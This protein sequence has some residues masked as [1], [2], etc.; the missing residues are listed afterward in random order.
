VYENTE[1]LPRFYLVSRVKWARDFGEAVN[2]LR[3]ADFDP[4]VEAIVEGDG[5]PLAGDGPAGV[6][7][8][9]D[10]SP[11]RVSL[12]VDA[13]SAAFLATSET[14]YPG[15]KAFVDDQPAEL[16]YTNVAFRGMPIPPGRHEVVMEFAP[17]ILWRA[18]AVSA[19]AWLLW[20]LAVFRKEKE[21]AAGASSRAAKGD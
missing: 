5:A 3:S 21:L 13:P 20:C 14:Q 18:A 16:L 8:V 15:W 1:V 9:T 17:A 10:Y 7:I 4:R 12:E 11:L 19:V 2:W 6:V